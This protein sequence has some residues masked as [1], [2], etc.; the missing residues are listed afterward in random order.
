MGEIPNPELH[1]ALL[2][3][4]HLWRDEF[5]AAC[6]RPRTPVT[7]DTPVMVTVDL[8]EILAR[9]AEIESEP[10]VTYDDATGDAYDAATG[11]LITEDPGTHSS[12]VW[13]YVESLD[14]WDEWRQEQIDPWQY[15]NV[16]AL[17]SGIDIIWDE[18]RKE[19]VA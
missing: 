5:C 12:E 16:I 14:A 2:E 7:P 13:D 19:W 4:E 9:L 10:T 18:Q 11:V 6:G 8:A 3:D 1:C 15:G 17:R